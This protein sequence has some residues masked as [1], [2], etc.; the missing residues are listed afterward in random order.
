[1]SLL[2]VGCERAYAHKEGEFIGN[3]HVESKNDEEVALFKQSNGK[4][5]N[6]FWKDD[7]PIELKVGK[8]Y[9]VT[10]QTSDD[11]TDYL[12]IIDLEEIK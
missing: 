12:E 9:R 5:L 2:L 11:F 8:K 1:M 4:I 3:I 6:L 7:K 10:Y